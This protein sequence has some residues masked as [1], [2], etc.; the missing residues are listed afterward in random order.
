VVVNPARAMNVH[1]PT[2]A[3]ILA[4]VNQLYAEAGANPRDTNSHTEHG[5]GF[6]AAA[7]WNMLGEFGYTHE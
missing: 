5:R 1:E 7:A 2:P 4:G 6:D 3:A